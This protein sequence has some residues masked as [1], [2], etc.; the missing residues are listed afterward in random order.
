MAQVGREPKRHWKDPSSHL[1]I[2]HFHRYT[3]RAFLHRPKAQSIRWPVPPQISHPLDPSPPIVTE[4]YPF[5]TLWVDKEELTFYNVEI[6]YPI[7]LELIGMEHLQKHIK[8]RDKK[9]ER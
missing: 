2:V 9:K 6:L 7:V 3:H 5:V 1:S 8:I 4:Q